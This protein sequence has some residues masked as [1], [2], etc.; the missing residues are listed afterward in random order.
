MSVNS[1][2]QSHPLSAFVCNIPQS[3]TPRWTAQSSILP[4]F[5]GPSPTHSLLSSKRSNSSVEKPEV[6]S[7]PGKELKG[8]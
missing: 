7:Q 4:P 1:R 5:L 2:K 8:E 3:P 6:P